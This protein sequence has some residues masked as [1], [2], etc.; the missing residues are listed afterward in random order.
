MSSG[1]S[2]AGDRALGGDRRHRGRRL[3]RRGDPS[4]AD[5]RP[6]HDPLVGRVDEP[7]EVGVGQDC[8]GRIASPAGDVGCVRGSCVTR[9]DL[10]EW[11]LGLDEGAGLGHDPRRRVRRCRS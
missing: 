3:V 2:P 4:L 1:S 6:R 11:L 5:A 9:L 8:V 7:L 10:D